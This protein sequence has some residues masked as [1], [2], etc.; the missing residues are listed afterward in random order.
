MQRQNQHIVLIWL[1]LGGA[2]FFWLIL[3]SSPVCGQRLPKYLELVH[4]DS[5]RY[6]KIN[7]VEITQIIGN[8]FFRKGI[9]ELH[10]DHA[11]YYHQRDF[12]ELL[13]KVEF[14]D[15]CRYLSAEQ[16]EYY[17]EPERELACGKVHLIV[18]HNEIF[19]DEMDYLVYKEFLFATGA[20]QFEDLDNGVR[21]FGGHVT[22]DRV[23]EFGQVEIKPKLVKLDSLKKPELTI[24]ARLLDYD[25]MKKQASAQ[26]SVVITRRDVIAYAA[27]TTYFESEDR[28][29]IQG[30]PQVIQ[31]HDHMTA[32]E[33]E[34]FIQNNQ[35]HQ[36]HLK[37]KG[38]LSSA[39]L[40]DGQ[41][42]ADQVTGQSIWIDLADDS[43]RHVLV[44]DQ[45][46]SLYHMI[47]D[48]KVTG[49][50]QVMGDGIELFFAAG[51]VEV[52]N[53]F[54]KP[55]VSRG[56]FYPPDMKLEKMVWSK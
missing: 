38:Q 4:A 28:L 47:E 48:G 45:A 37:G 10:C 11:L 9:K 21:L 50:N 1:F 27:K 35:V 7:G 22:F 54:S 8:V 40:I 12:T 14:L 20:V 36:A 29:L 56:Q 2:L 6:D 46:T 3:S 49:I 30:S 25:G 44:E 5:M 42:A 16:V 18:D 34:L 13:G 53:I 41:P 19:A 43:L 51:K 15:S 33:I 39:F 31:S 26:D 17:A 52:V 32:E 55:G 24:T 23:S